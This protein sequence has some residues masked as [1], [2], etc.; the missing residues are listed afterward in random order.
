MV[1]ILNW[2]KETLASFSTKTELWTSN[3][4]K[5]PAAQAFQ[6]SRNSNPRYCVLTQHYNT[7]VTKHPIGKSGS[8]T[9]GTTYK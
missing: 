2:N 5:E 3:P 1:T 6:K 7:T 4:N 9:N 8:I